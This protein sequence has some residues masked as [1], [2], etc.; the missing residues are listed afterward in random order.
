[1]GLLIPEVYISIMVGFISGA[2]SGIMGMMF[3]MRYRDK[4]KSGDVKTE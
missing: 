1:M 3:Y 4:K 2:T